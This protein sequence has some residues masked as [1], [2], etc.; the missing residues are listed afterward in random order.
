[1]KL[2]L[3]TQGQ[4]TSVDDEDYEE[5]IKFNWFAHWS[6]HSESFYAFRNTWDKHAKKAGAMRMS[7]QIM[8]TPPGMK[9]DHV[10][11]DTL[12]NQ[13]YNLRNCTNAQNMQNR[14]S[15]NKGSVTGVLGVSMHGSGFRV[16][17][18]KDGNAMKLG[19]Y[20]TLEEATQV[21]RDA[22]K[23]YFGEFA[24]EIGDTNE[25]AK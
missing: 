23:E 15:A 6:E 11:H 22:E 19:S 8:S 5:L 21:R 9:C 1:M 25:S 13:K 16:S 12:N 20:R 3:L 4:R 7:R 2:I 10:D 17:I 18:C 24:P 14:K